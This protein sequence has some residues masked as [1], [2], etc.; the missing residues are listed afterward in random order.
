MRVRA[1]NRADLDDCVRLAHAVHALDGYPPHLPGDLRSFMAAPDAL[2]AWVAE[3]DGQI[4][5][6][7][8]LHRHS[9][10]AVVAMASEALNRSPERLGVIARLLVSPQSRRDG[11]GRSLLDVA[12]RDAMARD[13][14]PILDVA[15]HFHAAISL[16]ES[17]GW[18]RAGQVVVRLGDGIE[19]EELVYLGPRRPAP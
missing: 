11:V 17:C 15:T 5:G 18:M 19:L 13:R 3:R 9:S 2:A 7:V 1:R 16:Y 14:W 12:S 4:I 10:A 6:H 8:A